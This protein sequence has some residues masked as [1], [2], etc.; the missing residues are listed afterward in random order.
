M[1]RNPILLFVLFSLITMTSKGAN[2]TTRV[3]F[4]GNSYTSVNNLPQLFTDVSVSAGKNVFIDSNTPGG[5]TLQQQ[6]ADATTQAKIMQGGWDYVVLQAQSQEP[7]F[8]DDQFISQSYPYAL[9]LDSLIKAYNPCSKTVFYM[10]WGRKNGDA[11]NCAFFPPLCTYQGMD[12]LLHLRYCM[13]ADSTHALVS[14]VGAAW[15]YVRDNDSTL[16]LYQSDESHPSLAGSYIAACSFFSIIHKSDPTLITNLE[17]L[18]TVATYIQNA[19]KTIVYDSLLMWNVGRYHPIADFTYNTGISGNGTVYFYNNTIDAR[20]YLWSFG[21]GNTSTLAN[22]VHQFLQPGIYTVKLNVND[23]F[24]TDT[25]SKQ[26][27]PG[28]E[29]INEIEAKKFKVS[30]NPVNDKLIISS[31]NFINNNYLIKITNTTGIL[32]KEIN[33]INKKEQVIDVSNFKT[34]SYF[35]SIISKDKKVVNLKVIKN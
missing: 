23:C 5:T 1:K 18:D 17:G 26:V 13:M 2:D 9:V 22:P 16:E 21:D 4:I 11:T 12:S 32:N 10:T 6:S 3:L 14:P 31:D 15:H 7:S 30:P 8:P 28:F 20:N 35:I 34:G 29:G 27:V 33:S 25:I 24:L 19:V